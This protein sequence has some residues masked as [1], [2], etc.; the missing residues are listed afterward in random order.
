M[1]QTN[2]KDV[3]IIDIY[4]FILRKYINNWPEKII[5]FFVLKNL[6]WIYIFFL[7]LIKN[8]IDYVLMRFSEFYFF[9]QI[10]DN[11]H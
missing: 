4:L 1:E 8:N 7:Y 3:K 2:L 5:L 10:K 11:D 9:C 6:Y